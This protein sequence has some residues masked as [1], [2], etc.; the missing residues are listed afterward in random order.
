MYYSRRPSPAVQSFGREVRRLL[1][2]ELVR[3]V[4][5]PI[6]RE[7][8]GEMTDWY[9]RRS[10]RVGGRLPDYVGQKLL[11]FIRSTGRAVDSGDR[12]ATASFYYQY[13]DLVL[14]ALRLM[15]GLFLGRSSSCSEQQQQCSICLCRRGG[16]WWYS[17]A[18]GHRFHTKC[19]FTHFGFDDRC[20]L[21]RAEVL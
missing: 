17:Q 6:Q 5:S 16:D 20:P 7:F 8:L 14:Q 10:A 15:S 4:F 12:Q 3:E 19:V 9:M 2:H 21:C 13:L 1:R 18:C 11:H